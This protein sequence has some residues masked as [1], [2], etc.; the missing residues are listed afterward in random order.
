[1]NNKI[2]SSCGKTYESFGL[3]SGPAI[4]NECFSEK[5][6]DIPEQEDVSNFDFENN[7]NTFNLNNNK[8]KESNN[9][10]KPKSSY[11]VNT[12][13]ADTFI[14][15]IKFAFAII[16]IALMVLAYQL[17]DEFGGEVGLSTF[18]F[19]FIFTIIIFGSFAIF[20]EIYQS[21]RGVEQSL[22]EI[23]AKIKSPDKD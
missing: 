21:L 7:A 1:M 18:I 5:N 4:C 20:A 10:S 12:Y 16:V 19:G 22:K 17:G 8:P 14:R 23:N 9:Y 15:L 3:S 2:C 13:I 6:P 11:S